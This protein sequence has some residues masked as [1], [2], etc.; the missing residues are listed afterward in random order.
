MNRR[1][2][3]KTVGAGS[4]VSAAGQNLIAAPPS[5]IDFKAKHLIWIINGNGARKKEYYENPLLQPNYARIAKE[6]FVHEEDHNYTVSE[7][8][9]SWTELLTGNENQSGIPLYPTPPNY[10]RKVHGDK[11]TNYFYLNGVSYYRAWRFSEKYF[12]FHPQYRE[13][14]RPLS[15]TANLIFNEYFNKGRSPK[16]IVAEEFP[17][18][19]LT[20]AEKTQ[21]EEFIDDCQKRRLWDVTGLK[22]TAIPRDPFLGDA[23]A[24]QVLPHMLKAF[25]PKLLIYQQVGHDT[26]HGAGGYLR[27]Q[28][29]YFEYEKV[30][31]TTDE[32]L[33]TLFDFIKNDPYFSKNTAILIR[34]EFGRDDEINLYGEV[35]HTDGYYYCGRS[36]AI[37]WG[38]DFKAGGRSKTVVNRLDIVPT[39]TKM[40]NVDAVYS[41]GQ[42]RT[43]LFKDEIARQLPTYTPYTE[44]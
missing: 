15:F 3:L 40:F 1:N 22:N 24:L 37:W 20:A 25:K 16:Q 38:P 28:T 42:V 41:H 33:G 36:A 26:G 10:V 31:K 8:G 32:Q 2:F 27:Q 34:P 4:V 43:D 6:A 9:N 14:T 35:N 5:S 11:A 39:I 18:S 21:L 30:C 12:T 23:M 13:E 29:G 7:H 19:A 17:D 44:G